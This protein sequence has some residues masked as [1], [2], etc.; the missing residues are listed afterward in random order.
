MEKTDKKLSK[1]I[2]FTSVIL[3]NILDPICFYFYLLLL[4]NEQLRIHRPGNV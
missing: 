2:L 3:L 4:A 1:I